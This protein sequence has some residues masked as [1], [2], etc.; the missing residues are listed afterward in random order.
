MFT[1]SNHTQII[2]AENSTFFGFISSYFIHKVLAARADIR[3]ANGPPGATVIA[4]SFHATG[5]ANEKAMQP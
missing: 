1:V 5:R 3:V 2:A 4:A